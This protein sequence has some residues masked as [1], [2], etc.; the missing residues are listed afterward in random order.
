[1]LYADTVEGVDAAA[2]A[3]DYHERVASAAVIP[4]REY[5]QQTLSYVTD[6]FRSAG[7]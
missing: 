2:V 3:S 7:V 4:M 5:V 6:A 1:M